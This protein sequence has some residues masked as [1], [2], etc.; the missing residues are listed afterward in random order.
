MKT[1]EAQRKAGNSVQICKK[2]RK[3]IM[4]I[5]TYVKR[6]SGCSGAVE[7]I[8]LQRNKSAINS[9]SVTADSSV[10]RNTPLEPTSSFAPYS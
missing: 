9:G 5:V 2:H 3:S 1:V 4:Q 8:T 7:H 10:E 6:R